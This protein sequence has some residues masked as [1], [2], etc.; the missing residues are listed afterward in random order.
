[1]FIHRMYAKL[2]KGNGFN[3]KSPT[4][5]WGFLFNLNAAS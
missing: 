2:L 4:S 5:R 3:K 1:M